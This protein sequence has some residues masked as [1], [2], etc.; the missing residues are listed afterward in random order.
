MHDMFGK[1]CIYH[2]RAKWSPARSSGAPL[3]TL[4][5]MCKSVS[6]TLLCR[7]RCAK[8]AWIWPKPS[9]LVTIEPRSDL[10]ALAMAPLRSHPRQGD[11]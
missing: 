2:H 3:I 9:I 4:V 7:C 8:R 5:C 1:G 6:D 10:M 11:V